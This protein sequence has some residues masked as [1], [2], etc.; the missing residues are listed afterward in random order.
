MVC[1]AGYGFKS[2]AGRLISRWPKFMVRRGKVQHGLV[3]GVGYRDIHS[4]SGQV[5]AGERT[6]DRWCFAVTRGER[7]RVGRQNCVAV[8]FKSLFGEGEFGS[9]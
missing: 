8:G 2:N 6:N 5:A 1:V 4:V 9:P 3:G 7:R